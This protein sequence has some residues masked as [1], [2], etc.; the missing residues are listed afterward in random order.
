[1]AIATHSSD[2][3]KA[4]FVLAR[5]RGPS[6]L[7]ALLTASVLLAIPATA[8]GDIYK[9]TDEQGRVNISNIP[10]PDT[11]KAKDVEL[12]L[13]E[14]KTAAVKQHLATPTEQAL[15]A[16]IESLERQLQSRQYATQAPPAPPSYESY[17]PP[18]PPPPSY[19]A[20][21]YPSYYPNYYPSY[22]AGY[23][24]AYSYPIVS[25]YVAYP[26]RIHMTR[27]LFVAPRGGFSHAGGGHGGHRGRR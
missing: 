22:Y 4:A 13:K 16:R 14:P 18:A 27:P 25:S 7:P 24:P 1:L 3:A 11:G 26:A 12:V 17:Y 19:Y 21:P 9:W 15:L 8:L 6:W 10:P 2:R 5:F 23:Y 20:G